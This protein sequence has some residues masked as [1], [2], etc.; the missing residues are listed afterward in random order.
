MQKYVK[1]AVFLKV[2]T[3]LRRKCRVFSWK[4]NRKEFEQKSR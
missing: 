2:A 1:E 3:M 4:L